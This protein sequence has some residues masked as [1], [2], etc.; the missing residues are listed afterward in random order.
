MK[1]NEMNSVMIKYLCDGRQLAFNG[2]VMGQ[3]G[4]TKIEGFVFL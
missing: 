2:R 1:M 3:S 4:S